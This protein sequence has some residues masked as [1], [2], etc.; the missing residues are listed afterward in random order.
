MKNRIKP[1]AAITA[2]L[3]FSIITFSFLLNFV[4]ESFHGVF[5]Y[6]MSAFSVESYVI[7]LARCAVVDGLLVL[8]IYAI[9]GLAW[10]NI[11]W[12]RSPNT[13]Q[14][15]FFSAVSIVTAAF[16][17]Y[18]ALFITHAWQYSPLMPTVLGLGLSPLVQLAVTGII[19]IQFTRRIVD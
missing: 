13:Q 1:K 6:D 8:L 17:E 4:W 18:R 5:L 10:R 9:V 3:A 2:K 15:A 11:F 12:L 16:I 7:M 19:A 14:L